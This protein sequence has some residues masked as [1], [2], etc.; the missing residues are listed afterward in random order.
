ML[1]SGFWL[2]Y[3][4]LRNL[5]TVFMVN[6]HTPVIDLYQLDAY[7][8]P[9]P[10][11]QI[12]QKPVEPRDHA[13][14]M[15]LWPRQCRWEHRRFYELPAFLQTGDV[16]V[17]N[18]TRVIPA[19]LWGTLVRGDRPGPRIEVLLVRRVSTPDADPR[20]EVWIAMV[21][22][23]KKVRVGHQIQFAPQVTAHVEDITP[24]GYRVLRFAT[25]RPLREFL[26]RVGAMPVPPYIRRTHR[27]ERDFD[28]YQT[29]F[30]REEGSIAAP[31]AGLHFTPRVIDALRARGVHWCE[32]TLHV[33]PGTFRP[34]RTQDIRRHRIEPEWYSIPESVWQTIQAALRDGRRVLVVGTTTTRALESAARHSP[35]R[36]QGWADVT[37]VP[38]YPFR[39]V[40]NLLTNF[41]LPRSSLLVLVCALAGYTCV[42]RAYREAVRR[43]YRFYSY[44]D[45]MLILHDP[46]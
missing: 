41:H 38:G 5:Q 31:T 18:N 26:E 23:G 36:L 19:R 12:A 6:T 14:M 10:R 2:L 39:V 22:P 32:I 21:R 25:D 13:R 40:R 20:T 35:P 4:F 30:A 37:I 24:E 33:G 28:W 46:E 44:G 34:I 16:V 7:D 29:V 9:L 42:M 15:V 43:N 8:Y 3:G 45:C 11:A 27:D 17:V 1:K